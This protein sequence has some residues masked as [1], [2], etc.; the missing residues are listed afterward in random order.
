MVKGS[1][2]MNTV[3]SLL[4]LPFRILIFV[5]RELGLMGRYF[6]RY[7]RSMLIFTCFAILVYL[8]LYYGSMLLHIGAAGFTLIR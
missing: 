3:T 6:A 5:L 8:L 4:F 7:G 2:I 1:T